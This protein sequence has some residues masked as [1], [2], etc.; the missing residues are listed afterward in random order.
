[1]KIAKLARRT[2]K[3]QALAIA[4]SEAPEFISKESESSRREQQK[5]IQ[6]LEFLHCLNRWNNL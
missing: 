2:F 3:I 4:E 6:P 5:E 1:M